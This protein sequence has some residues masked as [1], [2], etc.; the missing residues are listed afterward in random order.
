MHLLH[1][2]LTNVSLQAPPPQPSLG[3]LELKEMTAQVLGLPIGLFIHSAGIFLLPLSVL[4]IL[5]GARETE[6][7]D[8]HTHCPID[9]TNTGL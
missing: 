9:L 3:D 4:G 5:L 6:E 2:C 8:S 1:R 7:Q